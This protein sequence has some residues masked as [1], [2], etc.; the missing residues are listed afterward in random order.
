[1]PLPGGD[2]YGRLIPGANR[3]AVDRLADATIRN[4]DATEPL[5]TPHIEREISGLLTA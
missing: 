5:G 3:Q 1:M 4:P 2:I